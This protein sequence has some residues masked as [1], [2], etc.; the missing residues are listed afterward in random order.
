MAA[1]RDMKFNQNILFLRQQFSER[2]NSVHLVSNWCL[3]VCP[4]VMIR[5]RVKYL[6]YCKF[7]LN[8]TGY[9]I[10][11]SFKICDGKKS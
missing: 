3:R 6:F 11:S 5:H 10:A 2:F 4:Y 1:L 7:L 8:P 9:S